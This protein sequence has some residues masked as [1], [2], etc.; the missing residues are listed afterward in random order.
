M[1]QKMR[2]WHGS[3]LTGAGTSIAVM[4]GSSLCDLLKENVDPGLHSHVAACR[5]FV[6]RFRTEYPGV[7]LHWTSPSALHFHKV[8]ILRANSNW[9]YRIITARYVSQALPYHMYQLQKAVMD[10]LNVP[11]LAYY[12]SGPWSLTPKDARHFK[13]DISALLLSYY[14]RDLNMTG[15]YERLSPGYG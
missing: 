15:V 2:D 13:D 14:W 11:F 6:T 12:L 10:E 8:P 5:S 7:D 1:L 3:N 9:K 4:T